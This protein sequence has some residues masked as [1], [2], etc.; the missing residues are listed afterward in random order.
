[1]LTTFYVKE[2]KVFSI[3]IACGSASTVGNIMAG[4]DR[5]G[6]YPLNPH[7]FIDRSFVSIQRSNLMVF[8]EQIKYTKWKI[9]SSQ[10]VRC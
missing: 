3:R 4:D 7:V 6:I 9:G 5:S 10:V 1:M 8:T 2:C